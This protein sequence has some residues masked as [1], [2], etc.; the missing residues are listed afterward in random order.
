M[1][2]RRPPDCLTLDGLTFAVRWSGRR[3]TVGIT[4][5]RD[6]SL[7][8]AA[9]RGL[10]PRVLEATLR[11]KLPWVRRKLE[12]LAGREPPAPAEPRALVDG[13]RLPYLGRTYRLARVTTSERERVVRLRRGRFEVAAGPEGGA[14]AALV[15]WYTSRAQARIERR[16]AH[17]AP[18]VGATPAAIVV[19]DLGRRRWGVC[20]S[21]TRAVTFHWRLVTQ[22]P[23]LVDYV[24]V[25]ELAH[26]LEPNHQQAFWRHVQRVL[27]DWRA[28]RRRLASFA[29]DSAL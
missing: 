19:R 11:A 14:R 16:V 21:Q 23:D 8:A 29:P 6:G 17:F 27:P 5:A 2:P 28:R 12:E 3:S 1:W 20:H 26:L 13:D 15:A 18:L 10:S 7:R 25:H 4:V 9:P 22:P 24:V